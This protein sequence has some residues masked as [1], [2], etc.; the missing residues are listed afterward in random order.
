MNGNAADVPESFVTMANDYVRSIF[1]ASATRIGS[2]VQADVY[3]VKN[4]ATLKRL[5]EKLVWRHGTLP[6]R[7]YVCLKIRTTVFTERPEHSVH[8]A[9]GNFGFTG[10]GW[11]PSP[12]RNFRSEEQNAFQSMSNAEIRKVW[13]ANVRDGKREYKMLAHLQNLRSARDPCWFRPQDISPQQ[14]FEGADWDDGV[15]ILAMEF[16]RS[17]PLELNWSRYRYLPQV[18]AHVEK[19]VLTMWY[20]GVIHSDLH[21][22]NVLMDPTTKAVTIIDFGFAKVLP[23]TVRTQLRQKIAPVVNALRRGDPVDAR[24]VLDAIWREL[25]KPY[26]KRLHNH[27]IVT[28]AHN[29]ASSL[30]RSV[31]SSRLAT[32]RKKAWACVIRARPV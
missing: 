24:A 19:A 4:D 29:S 1:G 27:Q 16:K 8:L 2:G 26:E 3:V 20:A 25:I 7:R 11:H 5:F 9:P 30:R 13:R 28:I 15:H 32:A 22:D 10:P 14:Y 23:D 31:R 18:M 6:R 21:A 12:R 17:G